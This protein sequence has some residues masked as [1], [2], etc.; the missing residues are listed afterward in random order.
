MVPT[1]RVKLAHQAIIFLI[2]SCFL[3]TASPAT[4]S[5][6]VI[7]ISRLFVEDIGHPDYVEVVD[8]IDDALRRYGLFFA[9]GYSWKNTNLINFEAAD[10]LFKLPKVAKEDVSLLNSSN[11]GY[12]GFGKESGLILDVFEPKEG[13]SY[14]YD[15]IDEVD[16]AKSNTMQGSNQWPRGLSQ[17]KITILDSFYLENANLARILSNVLLGKLREL[18]KGGLV[19]LDTTFAS[20]GEKISIMRIFHYFP[21]PTVTEQ[22]DDEKEKEKCMLGS[23]PHT[24]WGFLTIISQDDCGGLQLWVADEDEGSEG[25]GAFL[26]V[27]ANLPGNPLV[28]NGGDYLSFLSSGRYLSPVHRV[29]SPKARERTSFV[30]FSYPGFNSTIPEIKAKSGSNEKEKGPR[31]LPISIVFNTAEYVAGCFGDYILGK[32]KGVFS[33]PLSNTSSDSSEAER[34]EL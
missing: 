25:G 32:W 21:A 12:I 17:E 8:K 13:F 6:P 5:L 4:L 10:A 15:W 31:T 26:D 20:G 33:S 22:R 29:V 7:D 11:R 9:V 3:F 27:P 14:S 18:D 16:G 19:S 24:D 23:A 34:V 28:V 2:C 30:F 1:A